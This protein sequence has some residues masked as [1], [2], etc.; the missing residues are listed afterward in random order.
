MQWKGEVLKKKYDLASNMCV[1]RKTRVSSCALGW[2]VRVELAENEEGFTVSPSA[3]LSPAALPDMLQRHHRGA[4]SAGRCH[5]RGVRPVGHQ[6]AH[7]DHFLL[8]GNHNFT[9]D[10]VWMQVRLGY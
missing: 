9:A 6:P 2:G 5:V 7:R 4:L 10:N 8:R 3:S 1:L